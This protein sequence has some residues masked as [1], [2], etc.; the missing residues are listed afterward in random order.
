MRDN[1]AWYRNKTDTIIGERIR[2]IRKSADLKKTGIT[3]ELG[4]LDASS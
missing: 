1:S 3:S 2:Q 4:R